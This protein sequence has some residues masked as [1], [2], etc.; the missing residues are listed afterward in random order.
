MKKILRLNDFIDNTEMTD[1]HKQTVKK[2]VVF[3]PLLAYKFLLKPIGIFTLVALIA[4]EAISAVKIN[5]QL[6]FWAMSDF[7]ENYL[8]NVIDKGEY[9]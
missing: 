8:S 9:L 3:A 5:E 7:C 2:S 1:K 6:Y 4:D